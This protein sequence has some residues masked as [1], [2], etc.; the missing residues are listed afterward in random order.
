MI[1][2]DTMPNIAGEGQEAIITSRV[3]FIII[4]KIIFL[5]V[6]EFLITK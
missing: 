1:P 5:A 3:D 6:P 2:H 4:S